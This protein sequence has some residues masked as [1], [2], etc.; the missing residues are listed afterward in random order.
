LIPRPGAV[1]S[2]LLTLW[3]STLAAQPPDTASSG[4]IRF[5]PG[6]PLFPRLTAHVEEPRTGIRKSFGSSRLK[7]DIGAAYD[8]L[9]WHPA[10]DTTTALRVGTEFF[11]YALSSNAN[12][13]RLQV[14]AADGFFGGHL[15]YSSMKSSGLTAIR[16]RILHLSAH[17]LD[18]HLGGGS[19]LWRDGRAPI[20][21][22]R[23]F[24]ELTVLWRRTTGRGHFQLY[25]GAAYATLIRPT[26]INRWSFL[27]GG[28]YVDAGPARNF[29]GQPCH[30]YAAL[31]FTLAGIPAWTGTTHIETGV[32]FGSWDRAG[33]RIYLSYQAGLESFHQYF[34]VRENSWGAGIA[35]DL[36]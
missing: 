20:A 11:T 6:V 32:R 36:W 17:F 9:E 14:D 13:L 4:S 24:G 31:H 27:A 33:T 2:A 29:F 22:S 1:C 23:D 10:D 25:G 30:L 8:L 15:L 34:D 18:G 7:L 28:E 19:E 5:L 16:L 26:E 35:F 21:Y 3:G 12:G